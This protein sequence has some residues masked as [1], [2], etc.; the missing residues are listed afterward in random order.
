MSAIERLISGISGGSV[1]SKL[2][3]TPLRGAACRFSNIF[4]TPTR[5]SSRTSAKSTTEEDCDPLI[6]QPYDITLFL[7]YAQEKLGVQ[8]ALTYE[9]ALQDAAFGP[10]ILSKVSLAQL[11][12]IG[13]K[14]GDAVRLQQ[15]AANWWDQEASQAR[16]RPVQDDDNTVERAPKRQCVSYRT[17]YI[18]GGEKRWYGEPLV[19]KKSS[20]RIDPDIKQV[21]YYNEAL[22]SFCPVPDNFIAREEG[23]IDEDDIF[24]S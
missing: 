6:F 23:D 11:T 15:H 17:S 8:E 9:T 14:A 1:H 24:M 2:P 13:I 20:H 5:D 16:K 12:D 21:E 3:L 18:D 10:D 4:S 7:Q 19:R 22:Q